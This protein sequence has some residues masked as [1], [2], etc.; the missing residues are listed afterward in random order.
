[1]CTLKKDYSHWLKSYYNLRNLRQLLTLMLNY[2][3][4]IMFDFIW[5]TIFNLINKDCAKLMLPTIRKTNHRR[6]V[7]SLKRSPTKLIATKLNFDSSK[8]RKARQY[9]SRTHKFVAFIWQIYKKLNAIYF[10]L[11]IKYKNFV[12]NCFFA[13][14]EQRW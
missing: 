12:Q 6:H 14:N 13:Y 3:W 2:F 7:H 10:W 11:C 5:K 8:S 4:K 1:M 9:T